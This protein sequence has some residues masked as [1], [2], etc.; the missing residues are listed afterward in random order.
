MK[1]EQQK[2]RLEEIVEHAKISGSYC[3][4]TM[5]DKYKNVCVYGLGKLFNDTFEDRN[6]KQLFHV[7]YLSDIDKNKWGKTFYG[8]ECINPEELKDI[9]DLIVILLIGY[10]EDVRKQFEEWNIPY[11]L[12]YELLLEMS[13][14]E[15]VSQQEFEKN[16]I[17]ETYDLMMDEKSKENYVEILANRLAPELRYKDYKEIFTPTDYFNQEIFKISN[18]EKLVDCGAFDGDTIRSLIEVAGDFEAVYSFEID[19]TNYKNLTDW[20]NSL[21][22]DIRKKI[23]CFHCGV[24]N[25]KDILQYG[26]EEKSNAESFSILKSNNMHQVIVNKL[27]DILKDKEITFIKMDIEGSE[28]KALE[29]SEQIIKEQKPKL[30]ICLYHKIGDFWKIPRYLKMLVPEYQFGIR[31]HYQYGFYGTV[32]YAY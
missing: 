1:I 22:E 11:I 16:T 28:L 18:Q 29:G 6:L 8:I 24:W 31:H 20:V 25:K 10:A 3:K 5:I 27:D 21:S 2:C 14:G 13:L 26:N 30:A 9:E 32:L 12:G 19:D 15:T 17:I 4:Q 23:K 7:N